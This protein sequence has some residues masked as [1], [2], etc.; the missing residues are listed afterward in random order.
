MTEGGLATWKVKEGQSFSA[1]DV[2]LEIVSSR[3]PLESPPAVAL[4]T[5]LVPLLP[6]LGNGQSH[7]GR[8]SAR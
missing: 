8:R 6:R 4:L 2:L 3:V 7:N 5:M 1:G